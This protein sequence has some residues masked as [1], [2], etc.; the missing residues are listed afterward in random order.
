MAMQNSVYAAMSNRC[1]NEDGQAY[2]GHSV[3]AGPD[4]EILA[5]AGSDEHIL[6]AECD[7]RH[8]LKIARKAGWLAELQD[9]LKPG[10]EGPVGVS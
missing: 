7:P 9:W 3:I 8:R 1:G 5:R 6:I 10:A 4:G 2:A